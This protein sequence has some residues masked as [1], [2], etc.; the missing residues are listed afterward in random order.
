M[1]E[2]F[3]LTESEERVADLVM[4]GL[5]NWEI[6][7]RLCIVEK[8]VKYHLTNVYRKTRLHR[9]FGYMGPRRSELID[10][11]RKTPLYEIDPS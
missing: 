5:K 4:Q 2:R 8:T 7:D 1:R 6:A 10:L 11:L 3:G 9:D